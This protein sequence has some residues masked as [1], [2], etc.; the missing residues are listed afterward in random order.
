MG[1][2]RSTSVGVFGAVNFLLRMW[3]FHVSSP[4]D[5]NLPHKCAIIHISYVILNFITLKEELYKRASEVSSPLASSM[6]WLLKNT[7]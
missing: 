6:Q 3:Q 5:T 1:A 2:M 7:N 4:Y